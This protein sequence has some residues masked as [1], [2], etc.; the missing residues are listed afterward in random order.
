MAIVQGAG[1][2]GKALVF[3]D[4]DSKLG[5]EDPTRAKP[6]DALWGSQERFFDMVRQDAKFGAIRSIWMA[7]TRDDLKADVTQPLPE[8]YRPK[9][10]KNRCMPNTFMWALRLVQQPDETFDAE[11]PKWTGLR[12]LSRMEGYCKG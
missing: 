12:R 8:G 4:G 11:S 10:Y 5:R 3:F 7:S 1:R 2:T 9:K 6:R